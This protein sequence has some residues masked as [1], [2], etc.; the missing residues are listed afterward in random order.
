MLKYGTASSRNERVRRHVYML[1][2]SLWMYACRFP[3]G[4]NELVRTCLH[5]ASGCTRIGFPW[6]QMIIT[7]V[8]FIP[9]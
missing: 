9:F 4:S 5:T 2:Y 8:T 7:S 3:V 6:V 1:A